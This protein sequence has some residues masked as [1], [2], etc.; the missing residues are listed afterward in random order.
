MSPKLLSGVKDHLHK[1]GNSPDL[2]FSI[3]FTKNN[4]LNMSKVGGGK[5]IPSKRKNPT[6]LT[7]PQKASFSDRFTL[8]LSQATTTRSSQKKRRD[9]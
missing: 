7:F 2:D 4:E 3:H 1:Y 5:Y 8:F 9:A 6:V